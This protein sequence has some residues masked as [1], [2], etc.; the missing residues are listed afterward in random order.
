MNT[1]PETQHDPNEM[2]G[3]DYDGITELDSQLPNWWVWLFWICII[4]GGLHLMYYHVL[5]IGHGSQREYQAEMQIAADERAARQALEAKNNTGQF[6]EPS[7]DPGV[8]SKGE[9]I[10]TINCV[11]CHAAQGQGLVGPNLTDDWWIHGGTFLEI[12]KLIEEGVPAK[13]MITW[14]NTLRPADIHAAAS[15]IWSIHGRDVSKAI[16]PP[17]PHE[18]EAKLVERPAGS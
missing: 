6:D 13:G 12:R 16:P 14:K 18:P 10:F 4:F 9:A 1:N 5:Q 2:S 8:L 7:K 17:K 3:H 11:V 15:Y